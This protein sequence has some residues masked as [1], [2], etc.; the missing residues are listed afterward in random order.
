[1]ADF[2][3]KKL[4]AQLDAAQRILDEIRITS[5]CEAFGPPLPPSKERIQVALEAAR[6]AVRD[7]EAR[8]D[9][10]GNQEIFGEPAWDILLDLFI[11][12]ANESHVSARGAMT[13]SGAGPSTVVRWLSVLEQNGLIQTMPDPSDSKHSLIQLTP[14]GYEG[15]LRYLEAISG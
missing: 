10:V 2:D 3:V 9:F 14:A 4:A 13:H 6:K 12:Q 11:R 8:A 15:M 1:M 5:G 7:R